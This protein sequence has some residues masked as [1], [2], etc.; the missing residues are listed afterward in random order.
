MEKEYLLESY[1]YELPPECVAQYPPAL[2]GA[3]RLLCL[4]KDGG[5][6]DAAF[7]DL[8]KHLPPGALL[9]AN[10]SRVLPARLAGKRSGGGKT[11]F[12]LLTPL[13]L[14][15]ENSRDCGNANAAMAE[16]LLRPASKTRVGDSLWLA[17]GLECQVRAKKEFGR[18]MVELFWQGDLE[19]VFERYG[20][21]PLPPYIRRQTET[22]D[23]SRYQTCY[24][25]HCGSVAAPTAGLHFTPVLRQK[26]AENGFLWSEITLHVGYGTFSPVRCKDIRDHKMHAEFV[27]IPEET[28]ALAN[29]AKK[30]GR[31]VVAIGTTSLRTLEGVAKSGELRPFRDWINLFIYPGFQFRVADG[32]ITNF[33]LPQSSLLMLVSAFAGFDRTMAAYAHARDNGYKFFS[34]GDAMLIV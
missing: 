33:H 26:L 12:L 27:E 25:S 5:L 20:S 28:A 8:C 15:L 23:S 17:P 14:V 7:D 19:S 6:A 24:A 18:H 34:Y 16:C 10:N 9:V 3:S 11:E 32:L 2:R 13:P 30:E 29:K 31:P 22:A 4:H 1:D 21:L